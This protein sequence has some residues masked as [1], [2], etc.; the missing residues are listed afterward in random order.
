M[1]LDLGIHF[2]LN[3]ASPSHHAG[4][5]SG[6]ATSLGPDSATEALRAIEASAVTSSTLLPLTHQKDEG[7]VAFG[8]DSGVGGLHGALQGA[9]VHRPPV[10]KQHQ[11][12]LLAAVVGARCI[13]LA[14]SACSAVR[15]G[16]TLE[17][18]HLQGCMICMY[19][20]HCSVCASLRYDH[21]PLAAGEYSTCR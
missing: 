7:L 16:S 14:C 17:G 20:L 4:R 21:A 2:V 10:D 3:Q 8:Q 5:L 9:A 11:D 6:A 19:R 13:P 15:L 1:P 12:G 18:S